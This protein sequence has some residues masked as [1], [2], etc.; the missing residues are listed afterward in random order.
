MSDGSMRACALAQSPYQQGTLHKI[1]LTHVSRAVSMY[2]IP[3]AADSTLS[4]AKT[5]FGLRIAFQ[6]RF[7]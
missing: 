5:C 3:I 6:E 7:Q 2:A 4:S 1:R